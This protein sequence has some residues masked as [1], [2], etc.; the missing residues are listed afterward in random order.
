MP[1]QPTRRLVVLTAMR[2][3]PVGLVVPVLVLLLGARGLPLNQVGQVMA[4]YGIV[5]LSLEL[6]TGGLADT[7]GRRPVVVTAALLNAVGV[8][9]LAMVAALP[10]IMLGAATLGIARALSSGPL[11]SWFVDL[12]HESGESVIEPGLAKGQVAESLGLAAGAVI[13]GLLPRWFPGLPA[14]GT[15]FIA[16]SVPFA[17][18]AVMM[19]VFALAA[20]ILMA[21][22]RPREGGSVA[23]TVMAATGRSVREPGVRRVMLVALFLGVMLS[24]IELVAPNTF[25]ALLGGTT[26][27]SGLY[28]V[29]TATAF[30]TGAAGA[31][32]SL[33]IPGRRQWVAVGAHAAGAV[34]A[35]LVAVPFVGV[36]ALS[37]LLVY[38]TVGLQGP[39][40]AGLLHD[41]VQARMRSTMMS[42]EGVA[43]QAG[44]VLASLVVGA[45]AAGLGLAAGFGVVAV[46]SLAAAGV[47]LLDLRHTS[48]TDTNDM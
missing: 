11:E 7:W 3:F 33:R 37:F 24:G 47:M 26:Q 16:L 14:S 35:L 28:G 5:T 40:M 2:W 20:A 41:R 32:L 39:V 12:Q 38:L 15:G 30:V 9:I 18:A 23:G 6:P 42:V 4:V 45:L 10:L 34:F 25:A 21:G 46:A 44:A 13:G 43:V 29:L 19:V 36:A 8:A 48:H 22:E 1:V 31:A 27:A 17:I